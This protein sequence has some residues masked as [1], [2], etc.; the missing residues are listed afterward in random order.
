M[1]K[2]EVIEQLLDRKKAAVL[3]VLL[4]ATEE[5]YLQEISQKSNVPL[6]STFRILQGLTKARLVDRRKWKTSTLYQCPSSE[7]ILFLREV[8]LESFD[9]VQEFTSQ[10]IQLPQVLQVLLHGQQTKKQAN[11]LVIGERIDPL[12]LETA[13][14][15]LKTKGFDLSYLLLTKEQYTQLERMGLYA[16]EKKVLY[17]KGG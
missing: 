4:A 11:I 16:G 13:S 8:F 1:G 10:A 7:G 2:K 12:P 3:R 5:M 17:A 6:S 15:N 14:Q 9:G